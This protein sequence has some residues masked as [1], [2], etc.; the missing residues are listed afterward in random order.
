MVGCSV[1]ACKSNSVRKEKS[2]SVDVT[3][4]AFPTDDEILKQWIEATGKTNWMPHK[5][6]RICSKH[7]E[8][9]CVVKIGKRTLIKKFSVPTLFIHIEC[10]KSNEKSVLIMTP[11][12]LKLTLQL[13][14]TTLLAESRRK[15]IEALRSKCRRLQQK[16][17]ELSAIIEDLQK[18][19][20]L[21]IKTEPEGY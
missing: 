11:R 19:K 18:N 17:A 9:H 10:S 3:F 8:Q 12:K 1:V 14:R 6:S 2:N 21:L 16:N 15:T 13:N 5:Y 4:H 20:D 7:F